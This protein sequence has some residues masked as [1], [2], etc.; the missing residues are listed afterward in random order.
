MQYCGKR[1]QRDDWKRHK[2]LCGAIQQLE[3]KLQQ[4]VED[5]CTFTRNKKAVALVGRRCEMKCWIGGNECLSLWDTGAMVSLISTDWL[6]KH[7]GDVLI[8]PISELFEGSLTVENANGCKIPY[9]GY[10]LLE[11]QVDNS[12][13]L[14]V[15]FLVT[16]EQIIQPIVGFNVIAEMVR[17]AG[18]S[19]VDFLTHIFPRLR[20]AQVESLNTILQHD[21]ETTLSDVK[22]LKNGC[23]VPAGSSVLLTCKIATTVVEKTTPFIFQPVENLPFDDL[24][25]KEQLV[26]L[27]KGS[28]TRASVVATNAGTHDIK[29]PGRMVLGSLLEVQSL[30]PAPVTFKSF[31]EVTGSDPGQT[32]TADI[33]TLKTDSTGQTK[34]AEEINSEKAP[35]Q[36]MMRLMQ[37]TMSCIVNSSRWSI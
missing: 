4:K 31:S 21:E 23:I 13:V 22:S 20:T 8:R 9:R 28:K 34:D 32:H 27:K 1:C 3:G 30:T 26:T 15:P 5:N 14:E 16:D 10:V 6:K 35:T 7:I 2:V 11:F 18:N 12:A 24:L 19:A 37:Q 33:K 29:V 25:L 36:Q 17:G